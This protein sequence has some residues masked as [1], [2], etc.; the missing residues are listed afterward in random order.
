MDTLTNAIIVK[1]QKMMDCENNAN[2]AEIV[3]KATR[4]IVVMSNGQKKLILM[5]YTLAQF[6]S[7]AN[8]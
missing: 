5:T 4:K 3:R 6:K 1:F 2:D 8:E 7:I